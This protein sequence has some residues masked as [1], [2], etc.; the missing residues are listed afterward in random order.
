MAAVALFKDD[1][2]V[3]F[4][5]KASEV[6][7]KT[8]QV[9]NGIYGLELFAVGAAVRALGDQLRRKELVLSSDNDAA[10]AA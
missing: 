10:A 3:E 4:G 9:T 6:L 1:F 8:L 5:G 7:P 2:V